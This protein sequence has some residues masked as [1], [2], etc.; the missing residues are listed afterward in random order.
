MSGQQ[1]L[2]AERQHELG[3]VKQ[4]DLKALK[5]EIEG[6]CTVLITLYTSRVSNF[7]YNA[8]LAERLGKKRSPRMPFRVT[9]SERSTAC[10][11]SKNVILEIVGGGNTY[12]NHE[13]NYA[14]GHELEAY[15][16]LQK[17]LENELFGN[18]NGNDTTEEGVE[19]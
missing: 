2:V 16:L 14:D 17:D 18:T 11:G 10:I 19:N 15:K 12:R 1:E 13:H 9:L 8:D 4:E 5:K 6:T 3:A 7:A